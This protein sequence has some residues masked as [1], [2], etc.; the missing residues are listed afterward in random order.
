MKRGRRLGLTMIAAALIVTV[1][2]GTAFAGTG[3]NM[4]YW[5]QPNFVIATN[6]NAVSNVVG[7]WQTV[8]VSFSC[9]DKID[10]LFTART[11]SLT[12]EVQGR[13]GISQTG[14]VSSYTWNSA[15]AF[16]PPGYNGA[17]GL[18]PTGPPAYS[19]QNYSYYAGGALSTLFRWS[20]YFG[21]W[22]FNADPLGLNWQS[23]TAA[24]TYGYNYSDSFCA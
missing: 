13:M 18:Q 6:S 22:G 1:S 10:G 14:V 2:P 23:A 11:A 5:G 19:Y 17:L 3:L 4:T 12:R 24:R 8:T 16:S 15:M 7:F 21:Q 20:S 9:S